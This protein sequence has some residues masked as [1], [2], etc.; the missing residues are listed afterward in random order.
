MTWNCAMALHRKFS[1]LRSLNP[2]IA[3]IPECAK[4]EI[5]RDKMDRPDDLGR[6]IWIGDNP[7]KGLGIFTFNGYGLELADD[8]DPSI[9]HI[10]PV[11]VSGPSSL[12]LLAVWAI[13]TRKEGWSK[14]RTAPFLQ[15][16]THYDEFLKNGP[17]IVAGD[18]NN[19]VRWDKPGKLNNHANAV[20]RLSEIGLVSAYHDERKVEHGNETEP[21]LYWRDRRKDGP[22]YHIDYIFIPKQWCSKIT[23]LTIG[24]FEDWCGSKL[25]DHVPIVVDI[26]TV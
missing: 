16:M 11:H 2:D 21:T 12:N 6:P 17:T 10:A 19:H 5:L 26:Q 9:R 13:N 7:N 24:S 18:F 1:A 20:S 25:S 8:Y 3:I 15:S 14:K 4:P 23:E 22:I